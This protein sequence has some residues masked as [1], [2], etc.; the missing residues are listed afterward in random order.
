[1]TSPS[2]SRSQGRRTVLGYVLFALAVLGVSG[3]LAWQV[4]P[5]V[6]EGEM[7]DPDNYMRLLRVEGLLEGA[8]WYDATSPRSNAPFGETLHW[9]RPL[10]ALIALGAMPLLVALPVRAA[11][12][13]SGFLVSPLLLILICFAVAG[14]VRDLVGDRYRY[15]AMIAVLAQLGVVGYAVPGRPD[16]HPLIL[17]LFVLSLGLGVRMLGDSRDRWKGLSAGAAFGAGLWVGPEFLVPLALFVATVVLLW[18]VD[19]ED[20]GRTGTWFGMGLVSAVGLALM[21]E[22]P[23]GDWGAVEYDRLSAVHLWMGVLVLVFFA[24]LDR[25]E[26]R[27]GAGVTG[28]GVVAMGAGLSAI[29]AMALTFPDFFGGPTVEVDPTLLSSWLAYVEEYQ[30]FP[31]VATLAGIGYLIAFL[32]AAIAAI[33]LSLWLAAR[34]MPNGVRGGWLLIG[35]SLAA[36]VPLSVLR[37]RF[38]AY[39]ELLAIP[40]LMAVL[41]GLHARIAARPTGFGGP[42]MRAAASA[43]PITGPLLLG[44]ILVNAGGISPRVAREAQAVAARQCS[45]SQVTPIL[46]DDQGLGGRTR[47]ILAH[48]DFG[49]ELL[50]RTNHR[51]LGT[52]YHRNADGILTGRR[53]LR[54]PVDEETRRLVRERGIDLILHCPDAPGPAPPS[55]DGSAGATD[56]VDPIDPPLYRRLETGD[57]PVWLSPVPLPE[58]EDGDFLLFT[59]NLSR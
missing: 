4:I 15:Y 47:T 13:V 18:I 50:Y 33:P 9:T 20:E 38:A 46:N 32:G 2:A 39:P 56:R 52:P 30:S 22:R 42:L 8:S 29:G 28:R 44:G 5:E 26:R 19:G 49:P 10:D 54:T 21:V 37:F 40:P 31:L 7:V 58:G 34:D 23:P 27:V 3:L 1:M 48:L 24:I 45:V 35:I 57:I 53:I 12:F 6:L 59:V 36:L 25:L 16:H 17:L 51:V 14:V 43:T 55:A 41:A 11:V